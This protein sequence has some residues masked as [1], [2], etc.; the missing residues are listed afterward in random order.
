LAQASPISPAPTRARARAPHVSDRRVPPVGANQRAHSS[1]SLSHCSV[2]P[3][4]RRRSFPP[5]PLSLC[6]AVPTCQL[7][8]TFRPRSPHRGRAHDRAFSGH[9]QAPAPRLSPAPGLPTP[10][11]HLCPLPNSLALSLALPTQTGSSATAR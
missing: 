7:P 5:R 4:C 6:S 8:L 9:V 1:P 2:G 11:S 3:S 10:L